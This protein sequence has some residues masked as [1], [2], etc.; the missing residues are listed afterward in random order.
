MERLWINL[1]CFPRGV[2]PGR[3]TLAQN[4]KTKGEE[5]GKG[6]APE[7]PHIEEEVSVWRAVAVVVAKGGAEVA[8]LSSLMQ[9][10][11]RMFC[12]KRSDG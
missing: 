12:K 9:P 4:D 5:K 8:G 11:G 6:A 10:A 1:I 2:E 3:P 7:Y